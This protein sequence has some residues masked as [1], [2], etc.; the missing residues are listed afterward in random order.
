M[1]EPYQPRDVL[2]LWWLGDPAQPRPVGEIALQVGAR[3]VTLRYAASWRQSGFALSEDL[4]LTDAL[5]V[6]NDK[7]T[8]AGA[9]DDA[10]PD[11]WG[12]RII[13][14]F[15]PSPRMSLLEYLLF[16]GD[17]RYGALGVSTQPDRYEP[18][19]RSPLPA[20]DS[21]QP[22]A[23]VVRNVLAN[24]PVP[25]PLR[26]LIRPGASL[27]G[28]RPKS[29]VNID[30]EAWIVKFGEGEDIDTPLV[31][32]ATMQLAR[33]CGI[34]TAD[35]RALALAGNHHAVAVRRFDRLGTQRLHAVSANVALKA[36]GETD[37]SYPALAQ[38][39]RRQA[40]APAIA[41]QQAQ[42]YR[43][44]VFNILIDN[45]DD[46]EKNHALLRQ[47]DGRY[48]LAPAYDVVPSAQGL[49]YQAMSVGDRG[50]ESTLAN[51]L[52]S[53]RY[54]GLKEPAARQLIGE[55]CQ[56]VHGWKEHFRALGV[57]AH[58]VDQLA[59]YIDG[60]RLGTER[61]EFLA[62]G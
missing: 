6:P 57:G 51:A 48:A 30:G 54:F 40:A 23:D 62:Y 25:E 4:P 61:G 50:T 17:D 49:G 42:L 31:E 38:L 19:E 1:A 46:H 32:H 43:R 35:T 8:A 10:R 20:L 2:S 45:T 34:H 39:L 58:D 55:I 7:D 18:W 24:E 37:L 33:R 15:E 60:A 16:A 44:M 41:A 53:A 12:E 13:R 5:F 27:G 29:L 47:P 21:L 52:T 28:A 56:Q 14:K 9:V 26:R 59:Q 36:A 3:G 11:R 22:M